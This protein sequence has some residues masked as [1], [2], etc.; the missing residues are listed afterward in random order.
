MSSKLVSSCT[1]DLPSEFDFKSKFWPRAYD[2]GGIRVPTRVGIQSQHVWRGLKWA[3]R[4]CHAILAVWHCP[5]WNQFGWIFLCRLVARRWDVEPNVSTRLAC[6]S[7][8]LIGGKL[9]P[10]LP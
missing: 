7:I 9:F 10:G 3:S 2:G 4:R 1:L 5:A 6:F 8:V